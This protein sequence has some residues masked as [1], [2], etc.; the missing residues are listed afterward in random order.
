[1]KNLAGVLRWAGT[2]SV[3][4]LFTMLD[5]EP[6]AAN[7]LALM[8]LLGRLGPA[9][10]DAARLRVKRPEWY[11]VRNACKVLGDLKDPS[12]LQFIA[13]ALEFKDERVQKTA[14]QAVLESRLPG[15][16]SVLANALRHLAPALLEDALCELMFQADPHS[17]PGLEAYLAS[18]SSTNKRMPRIVNVISAV[19]HDDATNVLSRLAYNELMD[20][21]VRKAAHQALAERSARKPQPC[22]PSGNNEA[23]DSMDLA[24]QEFGYAGA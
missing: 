8:R 22:K 21:S 14:L 6:L 16:A 2:A 3:E 11:V 24:T 19:Q 5:H 12:L 20:P 10:Y 17:L 18:S 13:P 4:R 15:R 7:R 23:G 9:A 1:V